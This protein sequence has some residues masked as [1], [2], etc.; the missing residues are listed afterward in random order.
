ME[1]E[2]DGS[3]SRLA[4]CPLHLPSAISI[5]HPPESNQAPSVISRENTIRRDELHESPFAGCHP[6]WSAQFMRTPVIKSSL[7]CLLC[8]RL[9]QGLS[10]AARHPEDEACSDGNSSGVVL[11]LPAWF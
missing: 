4:R 2:M 11:L 7:C 9:D 8:N 6:W 5:S 3:G 10:A 1:M